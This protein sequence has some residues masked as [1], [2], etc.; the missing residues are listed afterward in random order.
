MLFILLLRSYVKESIEEIIKLIG[1]DVLCVN[2]E[3]PLVT[4][5]PGPGIDQTMV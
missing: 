3:K 1:N 5:I 4:P 2:K